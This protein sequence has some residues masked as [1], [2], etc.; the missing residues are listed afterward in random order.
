M[1]RLSTLIR[2]SFFASST[3]T[4]DNSSS[5][6]CFTRCHMVSTSSFLGNIALSVI[7]TPIS[8]LRPLVMR[9]NSSRNSSAVILFLIWRSANWR[10]M[11]DMMG[12]PQKKLLMHLLIYSELL[13]LLSFFA[14]A[15]SARMIAVESALYSGSVK[16]W[17][18]FQ[19]LSPNPL[20]RITSTCFAISSSVRS[21]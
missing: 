19:Y 6:I 13:K 9:Q 4:S 11:S 5:V 15:V 20:R 3:S 10:A 7:I 2:S 21:H 14:N 8:I 1:S 16:L 17:F 18:C 12:S